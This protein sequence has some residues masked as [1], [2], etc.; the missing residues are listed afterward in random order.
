MESD[1]GFHGAS[2]VVRSSPLR[3]NAPIQSVSSTLSVLDSTDALGQSSEE[4]LAVG[5]VAVDDAG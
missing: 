2:S 3:C 5:D 4:T 1:P